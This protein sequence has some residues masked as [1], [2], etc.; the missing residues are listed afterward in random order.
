MAVTFSVSL[1]AVNS[2]RVVAPGVTTMDPF[3]STL[4]RP[5]S[6]ATSSA[7]DTSQL[8]TA[9]SP[10]SI[11]G[12]EATKRTTANSLGPLSLSMTPHAPLTV[13]SSP[14]TP[15]SLPVAGLYMDASQTRKLL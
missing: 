4:P 15:R 11:V 5:G 3:V 6:I 2:K 14:A 1:L 12:G 13:A 8:R 9:V 10:G 7:P